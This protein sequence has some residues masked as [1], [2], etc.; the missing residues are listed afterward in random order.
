[1]AKFR[2]VASRG[3]LQC[4]KVIECL[5]GAVAASVRS[6]DLPAPA[7]NN[8]QFQETSTTIVVNW[9]SDIYL[10]RRRNGFKGR[11]C[12]SSGWLLTCQCCE[13]SVR[14]CLRCSRRCC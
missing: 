6:W 9:A 1:M 12:N 8:E 13:V 10:D 14:K 2:L 7:W 5:R 11:F 3:L 4:L